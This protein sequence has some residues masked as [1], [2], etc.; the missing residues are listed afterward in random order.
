MQLFTIHL[1][2][3][4]IE[5]AATADFADDGYDDAAAA[6]DDVVVVDDDDDDD[7]DGDGDD[8]GW[9]YFKQIHA[10]ILWLL[11]VIVLFCISD[12]YNR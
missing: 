11:W 4:I 9:R 8:F 7:D 1:S 6:D 3:Q 2:W 5:S 12:D 10:Y